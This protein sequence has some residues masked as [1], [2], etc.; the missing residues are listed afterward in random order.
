MQALA[1]ARAHHFALEEIY[2]D[3]MDFSGVEALTSALAAQ[4][5][6]ILA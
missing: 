2:R 4:I 5:R 1:Q 3:T 6:E